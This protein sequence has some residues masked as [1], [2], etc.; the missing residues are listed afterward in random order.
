MLQHSTYLL[1]SEFHVF[2]WGA[3]CD[4][5]FG[6]AWGSNIQECLGVWIPP[7]RI[8]LHKANNV[9]CTSWVALFQYKCSCYTYQVDSSRWRWWANLYSVQLLYS[10]S[11]RILYLRRHTDQRHRQWI[12]GSPVKYRFYLMLKGLK[13]LVLGRE[14]WISYPSHLKRDRGS[15]EW[16]SVYPIWTT[17]EITVSSH[18]TA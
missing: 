3:V 10:L 2:D 1:L 4:D 11:I 8:S 12:V 5:V 15:G 7:P 9:S 14:D 13:Q 6:T 16:N 17:N 18:M